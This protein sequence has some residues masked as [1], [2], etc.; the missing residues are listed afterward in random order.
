MGEKSP[1]LLENGAVKEK[2][3]IYEVWKPGKLTEA[4]KETGCKAKY[5][6]VGRTVQK[7]RVDELKAIGGAGCR[8]MEKEIAPDQMPDY[9]KDTL[10]ENQPIA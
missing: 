8:T 2:M 7:E 9:I 4:Q 1:P 5:L 10:S 3:L 6:L